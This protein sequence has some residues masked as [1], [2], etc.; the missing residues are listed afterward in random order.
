MIVPENIRKTV[1]FI[2]PCKKNGDFVPLGSVFWLGGNHPYN[3]VSIDANG[4]QAMYAVTARHVIEKIRTMPVEE[5]YLRVNTLEGTSEL[6]RSGL[7][8]WFFS[9][10]DASIDIAIARIPI[11][12]TWDHQGLPYP[13]GIQKRH[14][15]E[16][17]IDLGE[18]VFVTGLFHHH[19][20][21]QR[22]IPIVRIGNLACLDEE[23]I[24]TKRYGLMQGIL[25]EARSIGGLSGSPVFLNLGAS[26]ST[27][28]V[29]TIS[30]G[31]TFF[32]L[33]AIHG[34]FDV[35]ATRI[36]D[37]LPIEDERSSSAVNTGIAIVT[38]YHNIERVVREY[39]EQES[40]R[41]QRI[42]NA[43]TEV[44]VGGVEQ[45]DGC[46]PRLGDA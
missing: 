46:L 45:V 16:F 6:F 18:E 13:I 2:G 15:D 32:L 26:R 42:T 22:N 20:G 14:F 7:S 12:P 29:F 34:H 4:P 37:A 21:T 11:L 30:S 35:D 39:E 10:S 24:Q 23:R 19:H 17:K 27:A 40:R 28:G 43:C 8:D 5:L 38:P 31:N 36:D 1:A 41:I 3:T 33:G 9:P 25:I 44:A